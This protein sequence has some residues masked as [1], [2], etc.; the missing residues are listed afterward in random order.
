MWAHFQ[1]PH[2]LTAGLVVNLTSR[3]SG[4]AAKYDSKW[5]RTVLNFG[6]LWSVISVGSDAL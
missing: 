3:T 6:P 4:Q 1:S 2:Y 5:W